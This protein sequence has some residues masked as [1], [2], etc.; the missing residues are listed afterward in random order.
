MASSKE[1]RTWKNPK[2]EQRHLREVDAKQKEVNRQIDAMVDRLAEAIIE[3]KR[4]E[5]YGREELLMKL[6]LLSGIRLYNSS[7]DDKLY[8]HAKFLGGERYA[9][10]SVAL[11]EVVT[12]NDAINL[13]INRDSQMHVLHLEPSVKRV[14]YSRPV[15]DEDGHVPFSDRQ[16]ALLTRWNEEVEQYV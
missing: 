7:I 4:I 8:G 10:I 11:D 9:V 2:A 15:I 14:T 6:A 12:T 3:H 16:K 1:Y 13:V 5:A